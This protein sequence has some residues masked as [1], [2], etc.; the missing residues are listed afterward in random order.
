M[1]KEKIAFTLIEG[2]IAIFILSMGIVGILAMF[3]LGT[4][5]QKSSQLLTAAIQ[6]AQERIEENISNSYNQILVGTTTEEY[7]SIPNYP[8]FKSL[9]RINY[10]DPLNSIPSDIDS[11]IKKIEVFL[12][13]KS[14]FGSSETSVKLETLISRR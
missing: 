3:P 13:W 6:L 11:G 9:V 5:V 10:Y 2:L 7:G 8:Y 4:Q 1:I 14:V 12:F